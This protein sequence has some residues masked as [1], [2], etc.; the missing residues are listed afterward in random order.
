MKPSVTHISW[1]LMAND[2]NPSYSVGRDQDDH[3][4]KLTSGKYFRR[5]YLKKKITKK[6]L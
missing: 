6:G 3:G 5:P 2:C 1:V 4:L